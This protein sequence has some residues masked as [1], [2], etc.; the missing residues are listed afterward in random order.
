MTGTGDAPAP[1]P[2]LLSAA[3]AARYVG[4][5]INRLRQWKKAGAIPTFTDPTSG[6]TLYPRPALD[7]WAAEMKAGTQQ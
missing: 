2:L 4:V 1:L 5:G 7:R 3:A 6:R